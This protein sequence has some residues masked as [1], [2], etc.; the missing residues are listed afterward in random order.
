VPTAGRDPATLGV[1][2]LVQSFCEWGDY[3]MLSGSARRFFA[4]TS[5]DMA[6]DAAT[7]RRPRRGPGARRPTP[8]CATTAMVPTPVAAD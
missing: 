4:G 5:A 1:A 8:S 2:L 6:S 3:M 7:Y